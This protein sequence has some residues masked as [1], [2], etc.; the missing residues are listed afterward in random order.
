MSRAK[1]TPINFG[2]LTLEGLMLENGNFAVAVPQIS[3]LF[4]FDKNQASRDIKT[5]LGAD[6]QFDKTKSELHPKE[7]NILTLPQL[8]KLMLFLVN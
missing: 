4:Q 1:V 5:L 3:E 6:F 2:C 8:E 7:V